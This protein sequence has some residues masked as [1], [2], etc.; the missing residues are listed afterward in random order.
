[1]IRV[2]G[3]S[4]RQS[5]NQLEEYVAFLKREK[6][7]S[8]VWGE[9]YI[10]AFGQYDMTASLKDKFFDDFQNEMPDDLYNRYDAAYSFLEERRV[11]FHRWVDISLARLKRLLPSYEQHLNQYLQLLDTSKITG[12]TSVILSQEF[13]ELKQIYG[14]F[15]S[16]NT[17]TQALSSDAW[18]QRLLSQIHYY[19]QGINKALKM[20]PKVLEEPKN[21]QEEVAKARKIQIST[22]RRP[23]IVPQISSK[24]QVGIF[25]SYEID[26]H[27][28]GSWS[29]D[30]DHIFTRDSKKSN[31]IMRLNGNDFL[32]LYKQGLIKLT[33]C[34]W[35]AHMSEQAWIKLSQ[36]EQQKKML[37]VLPSVHKSFVG[38]VENGIA[39]F[40]LTPSHEIYSAS[41][42]GSAASGIRY[43]TNNIQALSYGT[44]THK[45]LELYYDNKLDD[46]NIK[47]IQKAYDAHKVNAEDVFE[48]GLSIIQ[49]KVVNTFVKNKGFF[50]ARGDFKGKSNIIDMNNW[51]KRHYSDKDYKVEQI[52]LETEYRAIIG[53][54]PVSATIDA[55]YKV[56]NKHTGEVYY[57]IRDYKSGKEYKSGGWSGA[58]ETA[59]QMAIVSK[60][61]PGHKVLGF[62]L[63]LGRGKEFRPIEVRT[64]SDNEVASL[65]R[66]KR[67]KKIYFS[68]FYNGKNIGNQKRSTI[69][70]VWSH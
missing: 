48:M 34:Y 12:Q 43:G 27:K 30:Y 8:L 64:L 17:I 11:E 32:R 63:P 18:T 62:T 52:S 14:A 57:E 2:R 56:T 22:N 7:N 33:N 10:K 26:P 53:K 24:T 44:A 37:Q 16:I 3:R 51:Y 6:I 35:L 20:Q 25:K 46:F 70:R 49:G 28:M 67:A 9:L 47:S 50:D 5:L 19:L 41:Q 55:L 54:E 60:L 13:N 21:L 38:W 45:M 31:V 42:I 36:E 66:Q 40:D 59:I 61:F 65:V 39:T 23:T 4:F 58:T 1:M 29:S 69:K 68:F 15:T